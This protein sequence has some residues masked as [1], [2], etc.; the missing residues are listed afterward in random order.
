MKAGW[1][2]GF[3][4]ILSDSPGSQGHEIPG[5]FPGERPEGSTRMRKERER[6]D[7]PSVLSF[8]VFRAQVRVVA[9]AAMG[10]AESV[11]RIA[12]HADLYIQEACLR[13][14]KPSHDATSSTCLL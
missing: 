3:A 6:N 8:L 12:A 13:F 2:V 4:V 14:R 11:P 5:K 1:W 7:I 10:G 9:L